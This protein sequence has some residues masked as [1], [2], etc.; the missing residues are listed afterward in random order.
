M[1]KSKAHFTNHL[2]IF[3]TYLAVYFL[4]RGTTVLCKVNLNA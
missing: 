2:G 4:A 1:C 3:I